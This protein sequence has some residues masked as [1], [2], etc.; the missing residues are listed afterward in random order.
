MHTLKYFI[1]EFIQLPRI[2]IDLRVFNLQPRKKTLCDVAVNIN[3]R[4]ENFR[5]S[6]SK[7]SA[8]F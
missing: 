5:F 6:T 1:V 7:L 8:L 4:D 2:Q 3:D